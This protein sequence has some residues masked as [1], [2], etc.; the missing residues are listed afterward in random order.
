MSEQKSNMNIKDFLKQ[1]HPGILKKYEQEIE[2]QPKSAPGRITQCSPFPFDRP[3]SPTLLPTWTK[4]PEIV[5]HSTP[6]PPSPSPSQTSTN[7]GSPIKTIP[8]T[9]LESQSLSQSPSQS[10]PQSSTMEQL[11]LSQEDLIQLGNRI[12]SRNYRIYTE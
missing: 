4:F 9:Q 3:A 11:G 8:E 12:D 7:I 5:Y 2:K 10:P 6:T 1:Q